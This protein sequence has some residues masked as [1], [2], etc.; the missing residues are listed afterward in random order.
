MKGGGHKGILGT[1][2]TAR[3]QRE[4]GVCRKHQAVRMEWGRGDA[5]DIRG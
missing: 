2:A 5:G 3:G 1:R 4:H